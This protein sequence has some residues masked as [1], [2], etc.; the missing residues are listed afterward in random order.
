MV[1][2]MQEN[3]CRVGRKKLTLGVQ[4]LL[5]SLWSL[6]QDSSLTTPLLLERWQAMLADHPDK[7]CQLLYVSVVNNEF[8]IGF[9]QGSPLLSA[10]KNLQSAADHP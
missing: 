1:M 2:D 8:C 6:Q 9:R 7:T 5:D 3:T 10:K 4:W